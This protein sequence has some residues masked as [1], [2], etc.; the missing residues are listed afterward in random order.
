[1]RATRGWTE[2]SISSGRA[3]LATIAIPTLT[4]GD[5]LADCLQSLSRQ[6]TDAFEMVVVDNS[7]RGLVRRQGEAERAG[8]R[9][10][11]MD[12]NTGFGAAINSVYQMSAAPY[13]AT[14]NDDAAPAPGWLAALI[15]A[16]DRNPRAG[17]CASQVRLSPSDVLD[18]A[19]MLLCADGSSKQRGHN[20]SPAH[21]SSPGEILLP[22]ASAALYRR[23]MLNETGAFDANFFLYCEDTDLGLRGQRAGWTCLYA[24]NALVSHRYSHSTG[25]VSALKAYYVERNRLFVA[26]KNLP[27]PMLLASPFVTAARYGWHLY[28]LLHGTGAAARFAMESGA[29]WRLAWFVLKAHLALLANLPQLLK[30]RRRIA[31]TAKLTGPEYSSLLRRHAIPAR[32]IAE[33]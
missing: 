12:H 20:Q 2:S 10:V 17:M 16:L 18:S 5:A 22:S 11:E 3:L 9:I 24:P 14:L 19:G 28:F 30:Q 31:R 23:A 7:G 27:L 21:F 25:R 15:A 33:F 29:G 4:A 1:M 6:T 32:A 26:V 8:A 13:L